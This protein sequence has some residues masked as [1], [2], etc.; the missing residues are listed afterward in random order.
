MFFSNLND[1]FFKYYNYCIR[2]YQLQCGFH[3]NLVIVLIEC[4]FTFYFLLSCVWCVSN[5]WLK[6]SSMWTCLT[7]FLF[8]IILVVY[9]YSNSHSLLTSPPLQIIVFLVLIVCNFLLV[10]F[11]IIL[12]LFSV[13][14][15]A[16]IRYPGDPGDILRR[17][18]S[19]PLNCI[20]PHSCMCI[21]NVTRYYIQ[22]GS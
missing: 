13:A 3:S 21:L 6:M 8:T 11:N 9:M 17:L 7:M 18:L 16:V 20:L 4:E 10:L 2:N 1:K 12:F 15:S 14:A 22:S 5:S 19:Q